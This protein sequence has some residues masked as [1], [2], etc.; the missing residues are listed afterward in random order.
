M[1][2]LDVIR[3]ILGVE[4]FKQTLVGLQRENGEEK[5]RVN[6]NNGNNN[7]KTSWETGNKLCENMFI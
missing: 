5:G 1:C 4:M 7:N 3:G 2:G 6:N